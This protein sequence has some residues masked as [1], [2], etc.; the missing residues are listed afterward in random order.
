MNHIKELRAGEAFPEAN[1]KKYSAPEAYSELVKLGEE[2]L[3]AL[4]EARDDMPP[5]IQSDIDQMFSWWD[6]E[7]NYKAQQALG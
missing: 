2:Y 3:G 1:E 4:E 7:C 5:N 6:N